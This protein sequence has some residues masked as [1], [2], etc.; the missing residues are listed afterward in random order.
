MRKTINIYKP[1]SLTPKQA[2]ERFK[3]THQ[4]Y[5]KVSISHA[6]RLDP[7]AEGVLPLV[8][9]KETKNL[10]K[11][12]HLDKEYNAKILF[13]ISTDTYDLLG[14]PKPGKTKLNIA[15]LKKLI[16]DIRGEYLQ[17]LPPYSSRRIKGKPLLYYAQKNQLSEI[18]IP[19]EKVKI[20]KIRINFFHTL[21]GKNL[22]KE[23]V[24]KISSLE[25]DFMQKERIKA[26]KKLLGKNQKTKYTVADITI[27][28]SSGTY[29][30]SIAEDLGQKIG[31]EAVLLKLKRT[32]VGKFKIKDSLKV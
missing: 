7:L 15:Q 18:E 26:W 10:K 31:T 9:G 13:G 17:K 16:K 30:R 24:K 28:C 25:G 21:S 5:K 14:M 2:I 6:G 1:V 19:E 29:I 27:R 11:Y 4:E 32:S 22:L 20:K 8:I 12:L 3:E 23:V